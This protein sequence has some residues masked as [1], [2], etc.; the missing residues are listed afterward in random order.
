M[1][2]RTG[3]PGHEP[4]QRLSADTLSPR[5]RVPKPAVNDWGNGRLP[6]VT[7]NSGT[8][9]RNNLATESHCAHNLQRRRQDLA[10]LTQGLRLDGETGRHDLEQ[11]APRFGRPDGG[12]KPRPRGTVGPVTAMTIKRNNLAIRCKKTL[13]IRQ[14]ATSALHCGQIVRAR[15]P[16]FRRQGAAGCSPV[17]TGVWANG[18]PVA[19]LITSIR[20]AG[21]PYA[22][23]VPPAAALPS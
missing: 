4:A 19:R 16:V 2:S 21:W 22:G 18:A 1:K 13:Q 14:I 10:T 17:A 11:A 6:S 9:P 3:R 5:E 15:R 23:A 8:Y 12:P 20:T 7:V